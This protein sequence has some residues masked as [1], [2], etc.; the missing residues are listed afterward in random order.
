LDGNKTPVV[1]SVGN[2][3][4]GAVQPP[5]LYPPVWQAETDRLR[6]AWEAPSLPANCYAE[7]EVRLYRHREGAALRES[8]AAAP[9]FTAVTAETGLG[10]ERQHPALTP[11]ERYVFVVNTRLLYG[12]RTETLDGSG[13]AHTFIYIPECTPPAKVK[14][15]SKGTD[16]FTVTWSGVEPSTEDYRY[17]VRYREH[18]KE[19]SDWQSFIVTKG[20]SL[21]VDGLRNE[22]VFIVEVRKLC[23]PVEQYPEMYSEW[24]SISDVTLPGEKGITLPPFVCGNPYTYPNCSEPMPN[25]QFDTLWVGGFPIE[26][27]NL[28]YVGNNRYNGFGFLPLPFG[29]NS[30]VSVQWNGIKID[31]NGNVCDGVVR[32]MSDDP[33]YYPDLD[34]GPVAFGGAIC[35]PPPST[36]GFDTNGIHSVTGLPWDENG[37]GPNG[38]YVKQGNV[39]NIKTYR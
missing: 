38:N 31:G 14:V 8:L 9:C 37:F 35:V 28:I 20:L 26:V 30:I 32:G 39:G 27:T 18:G 24:V 6:F 25:G 1:A 23:P 17:E 11:G 2:A 10:Y 19:G 4:P 7:Y 36:P 22:A 16:N 5:K 33:M 34:P 13:N 3:D 12:D 21:D 15:V 29:G